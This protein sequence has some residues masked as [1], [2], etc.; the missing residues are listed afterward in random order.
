MVPAGQEPDVALALRHALLV[1]LAH[2]HAGSA[3]EELPD[4]DAG[5]APLQILQVL[6]PT[7]NI[8]KLIMY[9][10]AHLLTSNWEF[11]FIIR[12]D[13][14]LNLMSTNSVPRPDGPSCRSRTVIKVLS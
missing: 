6:Q 9:R 7:N 13:G 12:S 4:D 1:G 8:L 3:L 10:A 11:R 5:A 14:T 2:G